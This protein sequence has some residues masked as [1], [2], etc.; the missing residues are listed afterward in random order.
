MVFGGGDFGR[1]LRL[2]RVV[3]L[4]PHDCI[5]ALR[6]EERELSECS[7]SSGQVMPSVVARMQHEALIQ[8]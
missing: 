4:G 6:E 2:G 5:G 1:Y 8:G 3:R 7:C